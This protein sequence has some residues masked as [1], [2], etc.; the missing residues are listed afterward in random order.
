VGLFVIVVFFLVIIPA[1][2]YLMGWAVTRFTRKAPSWI[3]FPA[4]P[5]ELREKRGGKAP[6]RAES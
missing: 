6:P 4:R 1:L 5:Q 3:G 2:L